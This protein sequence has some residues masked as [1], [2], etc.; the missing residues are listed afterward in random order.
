MINVNKIAKK[1]AN[2]PLED[3]LRNCFINQKERNSAILL[4]NP[5]FDASNRIPKI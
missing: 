1:V 2:E 4:S 3:E 5:K